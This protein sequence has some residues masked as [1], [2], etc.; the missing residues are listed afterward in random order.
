MDRRLAK[1]RFII[2]KRDRLMI[3]KIERGHEG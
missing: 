1:R 2:K 3:N